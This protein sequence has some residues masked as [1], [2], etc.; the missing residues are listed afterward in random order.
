[1]EVTPDKGQQAREMA[2][3]FLGR[4]AA[5]TRAAIKPL[6]IVRRLALNASRTLRDEGTIGS[7]TKGRHRARS[8]V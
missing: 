5:I 8:S 2:D 7:R 6:G 1:M 4:G 3:E